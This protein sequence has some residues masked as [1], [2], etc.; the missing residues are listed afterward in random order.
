[1]PAK[2]I[3][4]SQGLVQFVSYGADGLRIATRRRRI[5]TVYHGTRGDWIKRHG[6][7]LQVT[8]VTSTHWEAILSDDRPSQPPRACPIDLIRWADEFMNRSSR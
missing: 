7:H 3:N 6:R 2:I 8:Q 4:R 1:M 5:Y